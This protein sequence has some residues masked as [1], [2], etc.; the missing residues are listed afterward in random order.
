[1]YIQTPGSLASCSLLVQNN[2]KATSVGVHTLKAA[3]SVSCA[4][5]TFFK[6]KIN[7]KLKKLLL[8]RVVGLNTQF[9]F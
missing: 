7:K 4:K 9:L 1:M 3:L 5:S 2:G 6:N 8:G